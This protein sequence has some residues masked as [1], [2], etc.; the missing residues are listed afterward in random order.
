MNR[1]GRKLV[2]ILVYLNRKINQIVASMVEIN[3]NNHPLYIIFGL[4]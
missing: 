2:L 1:I 3:R 4:I